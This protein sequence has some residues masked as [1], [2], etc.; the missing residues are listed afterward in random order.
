MKTETQFQNLWDLLKAAIMRKFVTINL[1][2]ERNGK[3][4]NKQLQRTRKSKANQLKICKMKEIHFRAKTN[5][6]KKKRS[7]NGRACYSKIHL[8]NS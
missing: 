5:E 3:I 4:S 8:T 2:I 6:L 7:I 1:N